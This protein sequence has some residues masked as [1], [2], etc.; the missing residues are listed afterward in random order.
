ML[1]SSTDEVPQFLEKLEIHFDETFSSVDHALK[2]GGQNS[3]HRALDDHCLVIIK[4]IVSNEFVSPVHV[5]LSYRCACGPFS[6]RRKMLIESWLPTM[7]VTGSLLNDSQK[8][9]RI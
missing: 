2:I 7:M 8:T 9:E 4:Y 1:H 3:M 5:I 6:Q